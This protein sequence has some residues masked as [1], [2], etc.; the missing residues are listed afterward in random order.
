VGM[1]PIGTRNFSAFQNVLTD[2]G[3]SP[4]SN[5]MARGLNPA[6]ERPGSEADNSPPSKAVVKND[7]SYI[8]ISPI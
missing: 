1:I 5:S 4:T 3:T 2:S 6:V 7:W 8:S